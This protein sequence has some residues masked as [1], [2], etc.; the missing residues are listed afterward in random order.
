MC[1]IFGYIGKENGSER[2]LSGLSRLEYRGYDSSGVAGLQNGKLLYE[3][4]VGRIANLQTALAEKPLRLSSAISHTRW[5]T[6]G[7]VT[8]ANAH[9]HMREKVAI[10][11]NGIIENHTYL[12]D[13]DETY[14]SETD[15]EVVASLFAKSEKETLLEMGI[16]VAQKLEGAYAIAAIHEE[17][18]DAILCLCKDCPMIVAY[19]RKEKA[20]YIASD[21]HAL[22]Q[23]GLEIT[24]LKNDQIAIVTRDGIE[25]YEKGGKP[26]QVLKHLL[27]IAKSQASKEGYPHYML[28]EIYEQP[29]I[30]RNLISQR[31]DETYGTTHFPELSDLRAIKRILVLGC[32]TSWHAGLIAKSLLEKVARIPTD[33][34]IASEFRYTNPIIEKNTLVIAISQ[35]GET[36]DL[37][38]A[39]KETQAKGAEVIA[40]CNVPHSTLTRIADTTLF[41]EAGQEMS[42]ASTKAFTSQLTMLTLLSIHIGRLHHLSKEEGQ[43]ILSEMRRLPAIIEEVLGKKDVIGEIA[44]KYAHLKDFFFLGRQLMYATG[45]EAALKLKE[46]SYINANGYAAGEMKHGPIALACKT[47]PV[48]AMCGN[49]HTIEKLSSNLCEI[50]ARG[51]PI[52]AFAPKD[53]VSAPIDDFIEM[54]QTHDL[55]APLPYS[56]AGQ[57]FAY[58]AA[59]ECGTDIDKPRNLAKSVTVE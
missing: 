32:G 57:L 3:K 9:P 16:D 11:H 35:S 19:D 13:Y 59:L 33:V 55:I 36:A 6:H 10:V 45:L 29:N 49:L 40:L 17:F 39:V 37:L 28:K 41:L 58:A 8:T 52:I 34:E 20:G 47:L 42:V 22:D 23:E 51:A 24:Y 18:P 5:A 4:R 25:L 27:D 43:E 7:K 12:R 46:I 31:I 30:V 50:H 54:P 21:V 26:L 15:S 1:G 48:V 38:A 53:A 56:V 2:C 14:H 44:K